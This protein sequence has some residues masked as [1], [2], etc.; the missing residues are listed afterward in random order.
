MPPCHPRAGG[1]PGSNG[2]FVKN[3]NMHFIYGSSNS[4]SR[5]AGRDDK[6]I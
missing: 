1:D 6:I 3:R 2:T 4:G 5:L